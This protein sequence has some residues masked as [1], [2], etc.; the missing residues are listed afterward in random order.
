MSLH[1]RVL[2]EE[3]DY[4]AAGSRAQSE[5]QQAIERFRKLPLAER[6]EQPLL[7]WL[8]GEGTPAFKMTKEDSDYHATSKDKQKCG[9]CEFAFKKVV[10]GRF[11][12]SQ[13]EGLIEP[14]AWCR[15]WKEGK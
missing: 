5:V 3:H 14:K 2:N 11:I 7:Y 6:R 1:K 9:N 4:E 12:C 13:I 8:L 15:L 10:G